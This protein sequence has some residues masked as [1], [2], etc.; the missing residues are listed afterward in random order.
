MR[1]LICAQIIDADDPV[2][3]F[4]CR[5]VEEFAKHVEQVEVIC[6]K[7]GRHSLPANVQVHS[8]GKTENTKQK[9][10]QYAWR[11][12]SLA[13]QLR[14]GYDTVFAHQNQEYVL[15]AGW[16]WKLLG[17]PLYL[18]R[19]HYAGSLLTDIAAAFCTKVFYTSTYSYTAK[20]KNA[21]IMPVG[22]DTERFYPDARVKRATHSILFLARMSPSKRPEILIEALAM[23]A[24]DSVDFTASFVGSP[25][26]RNAEYYEGLK[27]KV[28]SLG[29]A[30]RVSFR[31]GVPNS[32][33]PELYRAH[34]I[35]VNTSPSGM[36]DK[37]IYEAAASGCIVLAVS[38][39]FAKLAPDSYFDSAASLSDRLIQT[40]TNP[41]S[42]DLSKIVNENS[43]SALAQKLF[44]T[45]LEKRDRMRP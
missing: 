8:L 6:L 11:F 18:W 38:K 33:A 21:L 2:F 12:L 22:V 30:E 41:S 45:I 9:T 43:L 20:Y 14:R 29:L 44:H 32:E 35:F 5:W 37:T 13:W 10:V 17:K 19:N 26:P 4:F 36:L 23:L 3:G 15:L 16:L 31:Y 25:L 24:R 42:A 1:L 28:R 34:E 27:E 7:E 40:F 39:D